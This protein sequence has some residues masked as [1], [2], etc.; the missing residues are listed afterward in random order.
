MVPLEF[1]ELGQTI[2]HEF[3]INDD[4]VDAVLFVEY[5]SACTGE[6]VIV[7]LFLCQEIEDDHFNF[8]SLDFALHECMLN[9]VSESKINLSLY[10]AFLDGPFFSPGRVCV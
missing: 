1:L 3:E 5:R 10:N 9:E 2:V 7:H 4:R 8:L 6:Y